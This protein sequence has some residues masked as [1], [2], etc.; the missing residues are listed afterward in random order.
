MLYLQILVH[1]MDFI[2]VM[3]MRLRRLAHLQN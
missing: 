1:D 2:K 3:L